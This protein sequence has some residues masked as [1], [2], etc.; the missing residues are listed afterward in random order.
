[1]FHWFCALRPDWE[2]TGGAL[3]SD[4][5]AVYEFKRRV[6]VHLTQ[7]A[8]CGTHTQKKKKPAAEG[9]KHDRKVT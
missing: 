3:P 9:L 7:L 4:A 8:S 1:M 5:A 2:Q 6:A